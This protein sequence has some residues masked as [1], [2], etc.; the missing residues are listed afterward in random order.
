MK[1]SL[2]QLLLGVTAISLIFW[3]TTYYGIVLVQIC[4][5]FLLTLYPISFTVRTKSKWKELNV[6]QRV[7]GVGMTLAL[8]FLLLFSVLG[9]VRDP[10]KLMRHVQSKINHEERFQYIELNPVAISKGPPSNEIQ[11]TG[12]VQDEEDLQDLIREVSGVE[13]Y[14]VSGI[15]W[16]VRVEKTNRIYQKKQIF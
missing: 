2:R 6:F 12:S 1:F 8:V 15:N 4:G 9:I 16:S 13:W 11:V 5:L 3:F 7:Y 14:Q 10:I